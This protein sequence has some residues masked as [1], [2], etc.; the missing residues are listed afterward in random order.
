[1][2]TYALDT[3]ACVAIL[4]NRPPAVVARLRR[5]APT[6][7]IVVSSIVAF[8]LWY[9][10]ARS[11]KKAYNE[12]RLRDFFSGTASLVDFDGDDARVAGEVRAGLQTAGLPIGAYDLLIAGQALRRRWILVTANRREFE[13][14]KGLHV[15]DWA[16]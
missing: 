12:Q 3:N 1:V 2:R 7:L 8:E 15:E 10:S 13:R 9:G 14:V 5:K 4:E 6:A 11:P 16:A